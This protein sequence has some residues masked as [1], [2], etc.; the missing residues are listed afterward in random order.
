MTF[1]SRS[2]IIRL[3]E[4]PSFSEKVTE[5]S[6]IFSD[7]LLDPLDEAVYWTEYLMRHGGAKHLRSPAKDLYWFQFYLLDVMLF[8]A[9]VVLLVVVVLWKLFVCCR[10][11][12]CRSR[13]KEKKL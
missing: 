13:T 2:S 8:V 1:L 11:L 12:C 4:D 6:S 9:V 3:L 7:R 5:Y 10:F